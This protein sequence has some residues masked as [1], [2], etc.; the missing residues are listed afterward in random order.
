[1]LGLKRKIRQDDKCF[2]FALGSKP[3]GKMPALPSWPKL[4]QNGRKIAKVTSSQDDKLFLRY[5]RRNFAPWWLRFVEI[6]RARRRQA[7]VGCASMGFR[8][9]KLSCEKCVSGGAS[10]ITAGL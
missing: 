4:G 3:T 10:G 7:L 5:A 1:M 2:C 8:A 9:K 6:R